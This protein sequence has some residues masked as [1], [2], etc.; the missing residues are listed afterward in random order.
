LGDDLAE[1]RKRRRIRKKD[2]K[3]LEEEFIENAGRCPFSHKDDI[4]IAEMGDI[5]LVFSGGKVTGLIIDGNA[6]PSLR[7]ILIAEPTKGYVTVD[8]GAVKFLY[9]GADV[10][11]PGIIDADPEIREGDIVWA[12][13]EKHGKPLVVGRALMDGKKMVESK[14]GKAVKTVHSIGDKIWEL[15]EV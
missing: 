9:N 3:R 6:F 14:S 12:R 10:M 1:Y 4:D 5:E 2:A 11:A 15:D 13:E 8:M 7:G